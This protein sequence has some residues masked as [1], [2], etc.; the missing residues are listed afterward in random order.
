MIC[1]SSLGALSTAPVDDWN[2]EWIGVIGGS[3][4][5]TWICYRKKFDI[6]KDPENAVA[7]ISCDSKYWLWVNNELVVFEGQLKRGPTPKDTYFDSVDLTPHLQEG[8]NLVAILVWHFG[9][10]GFSHNSSGKAALLFDAKIDDYLLSS[11]NSWKVRIHPGFGTTDPPKDNVRQPEANI[12]FDARHDLKDWQLFSYDDSDWGPPTSFG[13]PPIEPWNRLYERPIPQWK[14]SGYVDYKKI[15]PIPAGQMIEYV[16]ELPY[17]CHVTPY[18]KVDAA[19]GNVIGIQT[20]IYD[21]YGKLRLV[22][23]HRHEYVTRDGVQEFELPCWINGHEVHYVVPDG[24]D[25]LSLKYRETGYDTEFLGY[26]ECDDRELNQLWQESLRTLYV[27]MRDTYMDCPDRERAQWW[28]DA[29]NEIGEAFYALD[30]EKAPLLA[31]KGIYELARWSREDGTLYSPVP[32]GLPTPGIESPLDGSWDKELPQQMLASIGWYGFWTYYWYSGDASTI[33]AVY[34]AVKRYLDSWKLGEDGLV[35]HRPGGW[36]WTDWG[37][38]IDVPVVENAWFYLALKGAVEMATLTGNEADIPGYREKMQSVEDHYRPTFWQGN[39]YRSS[40]HIG[41]T[42]DRANAMA[43]VAGLAHTV[44][45]PAI[46]RIL[47]E[48]HNASPY[49]EKYVLESLL[50]MGQPELALR[51][52]KTRYAVMLR[53]SYTTL[54]EMFE[55][56]QLEG[57][58][59]LGKGTYNHAW[60][61]GPLTILS[62]YVA[63]IAPTKP[64]FESY[65][66]FPQLGGLKQVETVVPTQYGE[67]SLTIDRGGS[68]PFSLVLDS[69]EGTEAIV[70]LPKNDVPNDATILVEDTIVLRDGQA[71]DA[72]LPIKYVEADDRY[73]CF[74]VP[75]GDWEFV[76]QV[77]DKETV[78][79]LTDEQRAA[80][81]DLLFNGEDLNDWHHEGNWIVENGAIHRSKDGG[82]LTYA[83]T[84]I[85]DDFELQFQWKVAKGSNSGVYYRPSQYEYQILDNQL[86]KDGKNP[87]TSAAAL[88]FCMAPSH[89]A[90]R[91]VGDWNEGRIVCQGTVIQHWLNGKKVVGFDYADPKWSQHVERLRQLGGDLSLRGGRLNLQD[92]G[93]PVWYRGIKLRKLGEGDKL[94]RS[95]VVP[96]EVS[97]EARESE[98]RTL[99]HVRRMREKQAKDSA[100]ETE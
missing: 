94:E 95:P 74:Q 63:G 28:G 7:R 33:E 60:S 66:V 98:R 81:F 45:Y 80:G 15:V 5:N 88:Y 46:C 67:I 40:G 8:E 11:D 54:W 35:V 79:A 69:P 73:Y 32:A 76:V 44:D 68:S 89:D 100:E 78:N 47:S 39:Q 62:Q 96:A 36:D 87:R 41:E 29:V 85:P 99:E 9:C 82:F 65:R 17:N 27:T 55:T 50:L 48:Q 49:M 42:D 34:P 70:G 86:H 92:H 18:L 20:D 93:D 52:M 43:V 90:T 56:I 22:E 37:S 75:A 12:R 64:A 23:S 26:F 77:G 19:A 24:V 2:A 25:V 84:P 71:F 97:E 13:S 58:G 57:F 91:P 3:K 51:R 30:P 59:S 72:D 16:C 4:P 10:H 1:Q 83:A 14:N 31:K 53:D 61:G 21:I 6:A 38:N